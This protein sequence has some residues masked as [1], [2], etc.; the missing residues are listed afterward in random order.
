V[1]QFLSEPFCGVESLEARHLDVEH[2]DVWPCLAG[3]FEHPVAAVNVGDDLDVGL[4]VDQRDQGI[5]D[6]VL[7]V[8]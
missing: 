5:A 1:G 3:A 6:D 2:R 8:G 7:V 4:E